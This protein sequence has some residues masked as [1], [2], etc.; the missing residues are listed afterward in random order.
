MG[1][2]STTDNNG[3]RKSYQVG[4]LAATIPLAPGET[5][6]YTSKTV[7]K[8]SRSAKELDESLRSNKEDKSETQR[9]DAEIFNNASEKTDF[10]ANASGSSKIGV[11]NVDAD[12]H[13]GKDQ[14]VDSK[15]TKRN[16]RE[17]VV[18]SA[19]EYRN[20]HRMEVTTEESRED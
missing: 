7:V 2:C 1:C 3:N 19:Q 15:N 8:K 17:S 16:L 4:N 13:F 20:E 5:R 14:G 18:K 10:K 11:Y 6:R 12:T 9:S